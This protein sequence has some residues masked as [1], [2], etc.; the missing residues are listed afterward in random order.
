MSPEIAADS[1]ERF[2]LFYHFLP[3][4]TASVVE[5]KTVP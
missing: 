5:N 2:S 1:V 3:V 4:K